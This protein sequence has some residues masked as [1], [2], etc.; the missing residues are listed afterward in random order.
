MKSREDGVFNAQRRK[1]LAEE[2][3]LDEMAPKGDKYERMIR[4]IKAKYS[5]DGL[6]DDEKSIAYATAQKAKNKDS[7]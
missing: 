1:K 4:H 7:K 5:K 3:N 6:T 2:D